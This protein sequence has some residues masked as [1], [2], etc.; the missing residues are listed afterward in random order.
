MANIFEYAGCVHK[1]MNSISRHI[2]TLQAVGRKVQWGNN[3]AQ[4]IN[5]LGLVGVSTQYTTPQSIVP[6]TTHILLSHDL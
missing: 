4:K 3:N 1:I 2:Q 5:L 6:E